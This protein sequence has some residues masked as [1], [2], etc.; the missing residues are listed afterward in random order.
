MDSQKVK[1]YIVVFLYLAV[2]LLTIISLA[3]DNFANID[4][5]DG[6]GNDVDFKLGISEL[7][8]TLKSSGGSSKF[9]KNPY[10]C[11]ITE[12]N[13]KQIN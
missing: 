13:N 8:A 7:D 12:F 6:T 5:D 2:P 3:I 1:T 11:S 10:S 9:K 4:I